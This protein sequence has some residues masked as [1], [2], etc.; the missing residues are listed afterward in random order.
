MVHILFKLD[1]ALRLVSSVIRFA[2][3]DCCASVCVCFDEE[4]MWKIWREREGR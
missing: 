4:E 2:R 1:L 3:H